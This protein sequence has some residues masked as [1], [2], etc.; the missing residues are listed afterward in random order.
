[1]KTRN[2]KPLTIQKIPPTTPTTILKA[3]KRIETES[4]SLWESPA[5]AKAYDHTT[6]TDPHPA[7]DT[8]ILEIKTTG[9]IRNRTCAKLNRRSDA[10]TQHH[11]AVTV[12]R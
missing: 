5:Y 6:F 1:L 11:A 3:P 7:I 8:G 4:P 12:S 10:L 9:G 2:S